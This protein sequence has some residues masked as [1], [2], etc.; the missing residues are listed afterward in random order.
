MRYLTILV[1]L[2][3]TPLHASE[4]YIA[5]GTDRLDS[6]QFNVGVSWDH[7]ELFKRKVEIGMWTKPNSSAYISHSWGVKVEPVTKGLFTEVY[8]GGLLNTHSSDQTSGHFQFM[9]EVGIGLQ[10]NDRFMTLGY[11][12][13][14]NAGFK[15]PNN[16]R[17]FFQLKTGVRF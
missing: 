9:S 2:L 5:G 4:V 11:R 17:D 16:G 8:I 3:A 14:S 7:N 12:H 10:D 13:I 15:G 6:K 1:A